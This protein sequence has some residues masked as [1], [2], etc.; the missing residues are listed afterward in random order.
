MKKRVMNRDEVPGRARALAADIERIV[1]AHTDAFEPDGGDAMALQ[2]LCDL[3]TYLIARMMK[4]AGGI[5]RPKDV[6]QWLLDAP[7]ED[8]AKHAV[9]RVLHESRELDDERGPHEH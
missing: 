6:A 9:L 7:W 5:P 3:Q 1:V 8:T 2:A 4:R